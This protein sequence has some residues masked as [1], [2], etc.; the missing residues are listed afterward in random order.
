MAPGWR[1]GPAVA[2]Q[3][4]G[5]APAE[6]QAGPAGQQ[7]GPAGQQAGPAGQQAGTARRGRHTGLIVLLG[8]G[9]VSLLTGFVWGIVTAPPARPR[10]PAPTVPATASASPMPA[11][12]QALYRVTRVRV[13]ARPGGARV[14]WAK[15]ARTDGVTA[16]IVVA[17]LGGRAQQEHTVGPT[18]HGAVFA[19]LRRGRRYCFVVGTVVET[20]SGGAGTAT[21]PETCSVIR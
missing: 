19:R 11:A 8:A 20:A 4:A 1:A 14:R 5:L 12:E 9:L 2:E 10:Q 6:P 17:E 15:P 13:V 7:A 3:Q 21:A 18:G 16:F